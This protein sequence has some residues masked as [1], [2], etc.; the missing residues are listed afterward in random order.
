V[1]D[2]RMTS[3]LVGI[4]DPIANAPSTFEVSDNYPNPFNPSTTI[5]Y[6][7]PERSDVKLFIYNMLGQKVRT[8]VNTEENLGFYTVEWNGLNDTGQQVASGV[9]IMRFEAA[10]LSNGQGFS[11]SSKMILL[12]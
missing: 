6:Q 10:S 2:V 7:L 1:D 4:D 12:K 5:R 8:L 3:T 11:R 9:Y